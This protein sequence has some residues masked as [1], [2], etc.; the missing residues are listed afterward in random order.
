MLSVRK[1]KIIKHVWV[2]FRQ[3]HFLTALRMAWDVVWWPD[4]ALHLPD[5]LK[6]E[7][8]TRCNLSC[9]FC[10]RT[11]DMHVRCLPGYNTTRH[12]QCISL[13]EFK[14]I[15]EQLPGLMSI[16]IQG[17][18]E[19]LLHPQF[20][21]ILSLCTSKNITMEFFTNA[22][23]LDPLMTEQI[24]NA[25]VQRLTFS[26]DAAN[27]Q[28]FAQI[29]RG[30]TLEQVS[31]N[32]AQFMSVKKSFGKQIPH[33]RVMMVLSSVNLD[34]IPGVLDLCRDWGV[35]EFVVSRISVPG[36]EWAELEPGED[37]LWQAIEHAE[38][39]ACQH[40]TRFTIELPPDA[41]ASSDG[42]VPASNQPLPRCLWPWY[43]AN[44]LADGAIT[45][46]AFISY[47]PEMTMGNIREETF[48]IVWNSTAYRKLR[49]AHRSGI[50]DNQPCANCRNYVA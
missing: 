19:P 34:E 15:V 37:A 27:P 3:G 2:S 40:G 31:K 9:R 35:D 11:Y 25:S 21:E 20:P 18:G 14:G 4:Y 30:A 26:V 22:T 24:L 23:L 46:C 42:K 29:R 32:I 7:I 41:V 5:H 17:T 10:G 43:A 50:W 8:T 13:D 47:A 44:I 28:L 39:I 33:T 48:R 1:Q 12:Q 45:P 36:P 16:D 38:S 49:A 6:M